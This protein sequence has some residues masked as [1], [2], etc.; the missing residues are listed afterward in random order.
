MRFSTIDENYEYIEQIIQIIR[1]VTP[2]AQIYLTLS[3][4]PLIGVPDSL[5]VL[6]RDVISKSI[7]RLAI[8][9]IAT[10]FQFYAAQL[11]RQFDGLGKELTWTKNI[12]R[13]R[14]QEH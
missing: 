12:T 8:E 3:P 11:N 1:S 6:E 7:L 14:E 2:S 10:P 9:R 4:V 13:P 5:S